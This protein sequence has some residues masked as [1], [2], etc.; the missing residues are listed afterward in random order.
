MAID[1]GGASTETVESVEPATSLTEGAFNFK[2]HLS[3]EYKDHTA[4]RDISDVNGMVKSYISAQE[5]IGQQRL[6]MPV[7]EAGPA[8][9]SKFYDSVGRPTGEEGKGYDFGVPE[10]TKQSEEV[11]SMETF[12]RKSMHEA[13]LSQKQ[14]SDMYKSY[15]DFS[16]QFV[17]KQASTTA[18]TEKQW[19]TDVRKEFGLA[20]NDQLES[21][22]AAVEEFGSDDLRDYLNESRL[23]NHPEMIKFA[24]KIGAQL[25]EKGSQ[26]RAGRQ[27]TSVLTPEQ[28]KNEIAQLHGNAQFMEAYQTSGPSHED[29]IKRMTELHDF[30]Y[31]PTE[32]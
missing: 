15:N 5:M 1:D 12:F 22:K 7:S 21:A 32:E 24:A 14:A 4:L 11:T 25:L 29:A 30:A 20:Y 2:E 3:P 17:E 28:A 16:G 10:G 26:G 23:G 27:G 19:D 6:P 8:E 13:G 18:D 31:P 9:W